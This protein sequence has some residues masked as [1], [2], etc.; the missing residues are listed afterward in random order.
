MSSL[1]ALTANTVTVQ[2]FQILA[3]ADMM[4]ALNYI[5][6]LGGTYSGSI[7]MANNAGTL[8][9]QLLI[10]NVAANTSQFATINDWIILQNNAL[11]TVCK[12]GNFSTL[13]TLG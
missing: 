6:G 1:V 11:V 12:S 9:W 10:N 4:T 8:G 2:G 7:Q 3:A 5:G 13:Y